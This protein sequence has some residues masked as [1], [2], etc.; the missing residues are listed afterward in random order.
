[1]S[2]VVPAIL[3][4]SH[5]D[6]VNKLALFEKIPSIDSIQI[7]VVDGR[8]ASPASWP[9]AGGTG[10]FAQMVAN[11]EMLPFWERFRYDI[12][13]MVTDPE[14]ATGSWLEIGASRLTIHAES[15]T[16]MPHLI[17]DLQQRYGYEKGLTTNALALGLA[18]GV[19]TDLALLEP[20]IEHIS[21][22]QFMGIAHIGRQGEPFDVRVLGKVKTFHHAH[23]DI[24]IQVDG[25][26]SLRSAPQLLEAGVSRLVIGSALLNHVDTLPEEVAKFEA[27]AHTY[28]LFA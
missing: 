20:F 9:Y 2:I 5:T 24:P 4:T 23:P 25:A 27:L 7:D 16:Y 10:E 19:E 11:D 26:V 6:L 21:Y 28:G 14:Q 1:M 22:V 12:D 3:P 15:T 17:T 8:F 18:L 13:L